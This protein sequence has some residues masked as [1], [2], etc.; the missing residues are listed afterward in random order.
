[1]ST[2]APCA[3][4]PTITATIGAVLSELK[5]QGYRTTTPIDDDDSQSGLEYISITNDAKREV[6]RIQ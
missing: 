2:M 6:M 1:M 4:A 5:K 3:S